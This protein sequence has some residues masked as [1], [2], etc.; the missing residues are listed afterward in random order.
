MHKLI[1][2]IPEHDAERIASVFNADRNE[3]ETLI[4]SFHK[5]VM[6]EAER[7]RREIPIPVPS[8]NRSI[9]F[10][11]DSITSDRE[12]YLHIIREIY[13][14]QPSVRITDAAI[15]GDKSDDAVMKFY[16]RTLRYQPNIA[17]I[18]IGTNDLRRNDDIN[19]TPCVSLADIEKNLRYMI[20]TLKEH[21]AQVILT[22]ISP[23]INKQLKA[24]FPDA[25][26]YYEH[27]EMDALNALISRLSTEYQLILNDMRGSYAMYAPEEILLKDGLH[28]NLLGQRLLLKNTLKCFADIL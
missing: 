14:D 6:E 10:I 7:I 16:E 19:A 11:G 15:S 18:L 28:L 27:K 22:T 12:S 24:R 25:N 1:L 23:V 3:V 5:T 26:W 8:G 21:G 2:D 17:C 20:R 13:R 4:T 9:V